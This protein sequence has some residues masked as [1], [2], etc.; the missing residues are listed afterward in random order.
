M[1]SKSF[2]FR[3]VKIGESIKMRGGKFKFFYS[4]HAIPCVGFEV[5][6]GDKSMVFS[7]DHMND[8]PKIKELHAQG[9]LTDWRC[10]QLLNFPW[11]RDIILHEAG[12]P[13]IHTPMTTLSALP[14]DVK[15]RLYVVHVGANSFKPEYGLK[16]APVGVE[17]TLTLEVEQPENAAALEV[18]DLVTNI[19]LFSA[20]TIQHARE[21][22]QIADLVHYKAGD[23]VIRQGEE[24]HNMM[25]IASG[26]ADVVIKVQNRDERIKERKESEPSLG[27]DA[28]IS[29][30][31]E[32]EEEEDDDEDDED[33]MM[34]DALIDDSPTNR[35]VSLNG[36][37]SSRISEPEHTSLTV[38]TF[39]TGDYF[40]EQ[41]L[42]APD[43]I[44][45][46]DIIAVT[47]LACYQF[48]R[49]DFNWLLA[50][51]PVV[52]KIERMIMAR[53]DA[54]WD[55]MG[56][57]SVLQL[58]SPTQKTQLEQ[59]C[60][61]KFFKKGEEVWIEGEEASVAVLIDSGTFKFQKRRQSGRRRAP[62]VFRHLGP[63]PPPAFYA[64]AFV[65][66]IDA[67]LETK[68]LQTTLV[69]SE[70]G[71][72][73]IITKEDL[74]E[75]FTNAPGVLLT[76]LHTQF[77]MPCKEA[78]ERKKVEDEEKELEAAKTNGLGLT[79]S[80]L[81]G[82]DKEGEE[83]PAINNSMSMKSEVWNCNDD[84]DDADEEEE[85]SP[86]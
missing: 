52:A 67:L 76:M 80:T 10:N 46:A 58:L 79:T 37:M 8:P 84:D 23:Y 83:K 3:P 56:M 59:R 44:R 55:L 14:D 62:S 34:K 45:S 7:G 38:K 31:D 57:N 29:E 71:Q 13:P 1:L 64:G 42:V 86:R 47:D 72:V 12:I 32:D 43:C 24:G 78:V 27:A 20:L 54:V 48:Q 26:K 51:T 70:E 61:P 49:Q 65:G 25:I 75:F 68:P 63:P 39:T 69:A 18:L 40:G 77:I 33:V 85:S 19:D 81:A 60:R 28:L 5:F 73:M 82:L 11:E 15:K 53:Q 9:V 36:S 66:E 17:N 21:I 16:P 50:G 35:M 30:G 22:L 2:H 41:A 74:L 4:L 6:L